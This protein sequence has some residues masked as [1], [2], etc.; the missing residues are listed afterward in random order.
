MLASLNFLNVLAIL[1]IFQNDNYPMKFFENFS[2]TKVFFKFYVNRLAD[3][4]IEVKK[5]GGGG[6]RRNSLKNLNKSSLRLSE[7]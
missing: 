7:G 6:I 1:P 5:L 3:L 2:T 4:D